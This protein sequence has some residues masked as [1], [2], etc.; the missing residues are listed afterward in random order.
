MSTTGFVSQHPSDSFVSRTSV[1]WFV[2]PCACMHVCMYACQSMVLCVP[3]CPSHTQT[4]RNAGIA[5][6]SPTCCSVVSGVVLRLHSSIVTVLCSCPQKEK[7]KM[8]ASSRALKRLQKKLR[9]EEFRMF[10]G[11]QVCC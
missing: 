5:R 1:R 7:E 9:D 10:I 6:V 3:A 11:D 2:S 8:E 4:L